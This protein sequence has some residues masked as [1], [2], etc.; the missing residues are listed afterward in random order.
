MKEDKKPFCTIP[1]IVTEEDI[2]KYPNDA[3][4]GKYLRKKYLKALY[5]D[6]NI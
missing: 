2:Q 3:E 1:V 4:L 6:S 5:H